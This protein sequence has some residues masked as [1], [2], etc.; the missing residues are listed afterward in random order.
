ML[1]SQKKLPMTKMNQMKRVLHLP[2]AITNRIWE[3]K[4]NPTCRKTWGKIFKMKLIKIIL[5]ILK[6]KSLKLSSK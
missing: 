5:Y 2:R 4:M 1:E 6:R 3:N